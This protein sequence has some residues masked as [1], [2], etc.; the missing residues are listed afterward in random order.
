[1]AVHVVQPIL[2]FGNVL[3]KLG[4]FFRKA[5]GGRVDEKPQGL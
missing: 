5:P 3:I 4:D 1:M 2:G